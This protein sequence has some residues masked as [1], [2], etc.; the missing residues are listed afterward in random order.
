MTRRSVNK[1]LFLSAFARSVMLAGMLLSITPAAAWAREAATWGVGYGIPYAHLGLNLDIHLWRNF[2]LTESVGTGV[3]EVGY[4]VGARYY[5]PGAG[6]ETARPRISALYGFYSGVT[7]GV[8]GANAQPVKY[9]GEDFSNLALGLG[10]EWLNGE[11][12]F[13]LDIY[14]VDTTSADKFSQDLRDA[15]YSTARRG[16]DML[17]MSIGYRHRF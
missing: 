12:G 8:V 14:L 16:A 3:N 4:A 5:L 2:Y 17:S 10:I 15:G 7:T 6:F 1:S 9:R 13:D 11:E